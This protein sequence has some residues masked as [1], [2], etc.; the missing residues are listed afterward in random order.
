VGQS[1]EV[2]QGSEFKTDGKRNEEHQDQLH[3]VRRAL[4]IAVIAWPF[5]GLVD[6][7][8]VS[9]V[10]PG[11]LSFYLG[12]R[13]IGLLALL[14][15]VTQ[16]FGSKEPSS[17][18]LRVIDAV[19]SSLLSVL[20]TI[21]CLEHD[22]IASPLAMGVVLVLAARGFV[23]TDH[24]KRGIL[25]VGMVVLSY[26]ITLLAMA[27]FVPH[28]A[29]QFANSQVVAA[30]LLNLTFITATGA[31]AVAGSHLVW[32]LR[33]QLYQSRALGRYKLKKR[34]G[35]GGMGEIWLAHH[36]ALRRDVAVKI[37]RPE[38]VGDSRAIAR[39]ER[40]V[41]AT[42]ELVHPN[43]V[44]VF[45]YGVTNDG[46]WYYAMEL[47][48]GSD[49]HAEISKRGPMHPSRAALLIGQASRALSEAH[50]RGIIHR[51]L[52]PENLFLTNITGQGE[53]IKILDFGLAKLMDT[54]SESQEGLTQVG[55]AVGTPQWVSPEVMLG[56]DADVRS[57]I[58]GLGAILYFLLCAQ[59]PYG[60]YEISKVMR[61]HRKTTP[62]RPSIR[63][64][65][66]VH[67][68]LEDVVMRCL[69]KD[70]SKRFQSAKELEVALEASMRPEALTQV[71]GSDRPWE[72][73]TR[74][75]SSAPTHEQ[76]YPDTD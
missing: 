68:K 56:E 43:T 28:M 47:L 4:T 48:D 65:Q 73:Q 11:R 33:R 44:R 9:F 45:D 32:T 71:M 75:E 27:M 8:I 24:W 6:W 46:L 61:A 40:E 17:R 74:A 54:R 55:W 5:F 3:R 76:Q 26:P 72:S 59:S 13:A 51:D 60:E 64:S 15:T 19:I 23:F 67:A 69:E 37:L 49:L 30:F 14:I 12:L 42:S 52:K 29:A 41:R 2:Q 57:D 70:P 38:N 1:A 39:F 50:S 18:S 25:P 36:N 34:I 7:Y 53:F 63:I 16:T 31:I 66:P 58:Y 21:S 10:A 62:K 20:I 22:G 35:A